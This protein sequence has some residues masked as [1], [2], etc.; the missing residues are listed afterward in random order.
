M[1]PSGEWSAQAGCGENP[2]TAFSEPSTRPETIVIG[3]GNPI[4]GDDAV[5]WRLAEQV[6]EQL[7]ADPTQTRFGAAA[8]EFD[9]LSLGGLSLMERLIGYRSALL[10]D[11]IVSGSHP[12]GTVLQFELDE[13]PVHH[14]GHLASAHDTSLQAA[15][16]IGRSL[17]AALPQRIVVLA[18]E[19]NLVYDFSDQLS[20]QVSAAL[21]QASQLAIQILKSFGPSALDPFIV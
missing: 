16:Q 18:I 4:L 10:I 7:E 17:G 5:G 2:T 21:P 20:P 13:L 6:Q 3:L 19:T 11:S 14:V 1:D 12:P 8:L 9:F 15:I